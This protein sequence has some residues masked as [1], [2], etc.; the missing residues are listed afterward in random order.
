[1]PKTI[2]HQPAMFDPAPATDRPAAPAIEVPQPAA[3]VR[4][5]R[6][7]GNDPGAGVTVVV[8]RLSL[9]RL[10]ERGEAGADLFERR[11]KLLNRARAAVIAMTKPRDW[12][13]SR[14]R[15]GAIVGYL[16]ST[17]IPQVCQLFAIEYQ[18]FP[19]TEDGRFN[20]E[21]VLREHAPSGVYGYRC[22]C[23]ASSQLLGGWTLTVEATRWNDEE[24][25]G[26][27]V[28]ADGKIDTR[29]GA[30]ALDSDL[31]LAVYSLAVAKA[32]RELT[33]LEGVAGPE[34]EAGGL[35]LKQCRLGMGFGSATE[36]D[37]GR[38]APEDIKAAAVELGEDILKRVGGDVSAAASLLKEI[39]SKPAS[40]KSKGFEGFVSIARLTEQ[41]QIDNAWKRLKAHP[42]FG[43]GA[44]D[45]GEGA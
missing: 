43:D 28:T 7:E 4:R 33:G 36:R 40:G 31:R 15:S 32:V 29:R 35:D 5:E 23:R 21:R 25:T 24:F 45:A 26:R 27:G 1:M 14:D 30:L 17:G 6:Q 9:L 8:E 20:P 12:V 22:W 39:T 16:A 19:N 2:S 13:L 3:L 41:W 38:V 44:A 11:T 37:A 18:A 42:T 34:L 10:A